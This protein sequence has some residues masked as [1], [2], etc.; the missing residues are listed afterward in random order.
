M[1]YNAVLRANR[2]VIASM[3]PGVNW[4][5]MH[6]LANKEMLLALTDGGVLKGDVDAMMQVLK[7]YVPSPPF[8]V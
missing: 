6:K 4:V 3:K 8:Q 7:K 2:A 1:I 5:D